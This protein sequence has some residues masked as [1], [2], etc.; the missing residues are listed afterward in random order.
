MANALIFNADREGYGI[1]QIQRTMTVGDLI[2]FLS[3]YDEDMPIY[4]AHD[5][6]YTFGGVREEMFEDDY[7]EE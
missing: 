1:D 7:K 5:G 4:T 2:D 6:H 3:Q